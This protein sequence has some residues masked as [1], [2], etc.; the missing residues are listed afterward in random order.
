[1]GHPGTS[2]IISLFTYD[3]VAD[4]GFSGK[5]KKLKII[6]IEETLPWGFRP[7]INFFKNL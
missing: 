4:P 7:I 2:G 1:M 3:I 5:I 6:E